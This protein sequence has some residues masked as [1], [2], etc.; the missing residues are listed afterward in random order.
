MRLNRFSYLFRSPSRNQSLPVDTLP[1]GRYSV[2]MALPPRDEWQCDWCGHD[3]SIRPLQVDHCHADD[4]IRGILCG[5]GAGCNIAE[6]AIS[7]LGLEP[8]PGYFAR[9]LGSYADHERR[10]AQR[11]RI[12]NPEP[13]R[14]SQRRYV[15]AN[16]V[17]QS[18][19]RKACYAKRREE[20]CAYA[21]EYYYTT[22]KAR[23]QQRRTAQRAIA[24]AIAGIGRV[25]PA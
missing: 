21:R 1:C 12:D 10:E 6:V 9:D 2:R 17:A 11:R 15:A 14:L 5:G 8:V 7:R 16:P 22:G 19:R 18:E 25:S 20:V 3:G 23:R 24:Q 4:R 13:R